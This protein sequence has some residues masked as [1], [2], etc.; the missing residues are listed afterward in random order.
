MNAVLLDPDIDLEDSIE[1][2]SPPDSEGGTDETN[3]FKATRWTL[4]NQTRDP[5]E[6]KV[7]LAELCQ[8]YW[9][10]LYDYVRAM[11]KDHHEAQDLVQG[12]FGQ[13]LERGDFEKA[14]KERGKLRCYLCTA[15]RRYVIGEDR[16]E[17]RL[18]RGGK[19]EFISMDMDEAEREFLLEP[20]EDETPETYFDRR[21]ASKLLATAADVLESEYEAKGHAD[22]F[23][24]MVPYL[25]LNAAGEKYAEI[26][27]RIGL[28]HGA[29]GMGV[30]RLR[31]R[32]KEIV[33]QNVRDTLA[34]PSQ[35]DEEIDHLFQIFD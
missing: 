10:P 1:M 3:R 24:E 12:Y 30:Y 23:A 9:S 2:T 32:Y 14:E 35:V 29:V 20:C 27:A 16:R 7:A 19:I 21:W 18:K 34:D 17:K 11:G 4:V 31:Q 6:R 15:V 5:E 8:I 26:G 28:T 22:Q 33:R 13:L 25:S